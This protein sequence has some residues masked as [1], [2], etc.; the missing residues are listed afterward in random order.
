MCAPIDL[1]LPFTS[2]MQGLAFL[3]AREVWEFAKASKSLCAADSVRSGVGKDTQFDVS[4]RYFHHVTEADLLPT[5]YCTS[6]HFHTEGAVGSGVLATKADVFCIRANPNPPVSVWQTQPVSL[7]FPGGKV[8]T[9]YEAATL[10]LVGGCFSGTWRRYSCV[11]ARCLIGARGASCTFYGDSVQGPA[12]EAYT[13][14]RKPG[15]VKKGND[16][17]FLAVMVDSLLVR[18]N[19]HDIEAFATG[20][21]TFIK[22]KLHRFHGP[23]QAAAYV[24]QRFRKDRW[25]SEWVRQEVAATS[26]DAG[27]WVAKQDEIVDMLEAVGWAPSLG[28][29]T[30]RRFVEERGNSD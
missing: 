4:A 30:V 23:K 20:V 7:G 11:C 3:S 21:G 14:E 15:T 9:P 17:C 1:M 29:A 27:A 22:S 18:W 25:V 26:G 16:T 6:P 2:Q 19:K 24:Q 8:S 5:E 28:R 12:W 10:N 13:V